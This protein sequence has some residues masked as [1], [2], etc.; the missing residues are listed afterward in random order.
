MLFQHHNPYDNR[1]D[2]V[3]KPASGVS[4]C[5]ETPNAALLKTSKAGVMPIPAKVPFLPY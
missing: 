5:A 2:P 1:C 4:V 3:C